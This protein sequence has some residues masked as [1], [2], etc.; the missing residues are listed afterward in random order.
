MRSRVSPVVASSFGISDFSRPIP[1]MSL[2]RRRCSRLSVPSSCRSKPLSFL[3]MPRMVS[4]LRRRTVMARYGGA[5]PGSRSERSICAA[6]RS[7]PIFE[8]SGPR[9]PPCPRTMWHVVQLP[10][11]VKNRS[12]AAGSPAAADSAAGARRRTT[13]AASASSSSPATGKAGMPPSGMPSRMMARMASRVA[14][15]GRRR[16]TIAGPCPPPVP[17]SPWQPAQRSSYCRLPASGVCAP[18]AH[19][20][21]RAQTAMVFTGY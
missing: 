3:A 7:L 10:L 1:A 17:S 14:A 9:M 18:A 13:R 12:P 21:A 16:F 2:F 5:A 19:D 4:P 15:R 6:V 11:P 20:R 8:R